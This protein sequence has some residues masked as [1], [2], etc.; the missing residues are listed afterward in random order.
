[1]LFLEHFHYRVE[2]LVR[3]REVRAF[4]GDIAIVKAIKRRAELL[5]KLKRHASAIDRVFHIIN[6]PFPRPQH[7]AWPKR[8][9]AGA[10]K[11]VP[12]GDAKT[13]MFLHLLPLD[14]FILVVV[15]KRQ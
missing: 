4:R 10:A 5:D 8:I 1:M 3:L 15:M 9:A 12:V 7:R 2:I 13:K 14:E 11:R 6:R